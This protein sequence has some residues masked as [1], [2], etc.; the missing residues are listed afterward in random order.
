MELR[1]CWLT[2]R[3][4]SELGKCTHGVGSGACQITC[5]MIKEIIYPETAKKK[6][7]RSETV[8]FLK[9]FSFAILTKPLERRVWGTFLEGSP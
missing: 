1:N 6:N 9:S 7:Q 3:A 4:R 5:S 8:Q 2:P